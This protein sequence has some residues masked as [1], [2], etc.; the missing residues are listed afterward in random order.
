MFSTGWPESAVKPG[1]I[2]RTSH[3]LVV[4]L[5]DTFFLVVTAGVGVRNGSPRAPIGAVLMA[6]IYASGHLSGGHLNPAVTVAAPV[7]G[8]TGLGLHE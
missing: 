1:A 4:E 6:M 7:R 5:I 3:K 2:N 8:Q